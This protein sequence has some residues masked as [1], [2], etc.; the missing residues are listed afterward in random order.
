M[1]LTIPK[2]IKENCINFHWDDEKVWRLKLPIEKMKVSK[3]DWLFKMP[4]WGTKNKKHGLTPK[5]VMKNPKK[6]SYH[7][8][9]ILNADLKH[10]IDIIK[11]QKGKWD[12]LDGLHRLVKA[13]IMGKIEVDVRKI[14]LSKINEIKR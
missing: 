1:D 6:Y 5:E 10:P 13:K 12:I 7:Y 4:F 8:K 11:T 9:K 14:P 2:I 3:L